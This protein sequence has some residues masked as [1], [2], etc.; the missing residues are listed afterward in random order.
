MIEFL[1]CEG[2]DCFRGTEL[3]SR[4][5]KVRVNVLYYSQ[6]F[7]Q[8]VYDATGGRAF[9]KDEE[10][11]VLT[12]YLSH[13]QQKYTVSFQ[14]NLVVIHDDEI[15]NFLTGAPRQHSLISASDP[16]SDPGYA[17]PSAYFSVNFNFNRL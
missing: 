17:N 9:I 2:P 10:K 13:G 16:I 14:R 15:Y 8:T 12:P 7:D 1:P 11:L 4:L 5:R 6:K 3:E